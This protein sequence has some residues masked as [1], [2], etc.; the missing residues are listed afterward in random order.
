MLV[1]GDCVQSNVN[2]LAETGVMES[3]RHQSE[4]SGQWS[5]PKS[6][7]N[8]I[9]SDG[10]PDGYAFDPTTIMECPLGGE[11]LVVGYGLLIG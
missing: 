2:M 10:I 11:C 8:A 9:R 4:I 3:E 5:E 6:R 1:Y 7:R